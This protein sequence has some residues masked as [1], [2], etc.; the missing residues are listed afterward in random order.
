MTATAAVY[1][2]LADIN[3]NSPR[4]NVSHYRMSVAENM[5]KYSFVGK[6]CI[7][8]YSLDTVIWLCFIAKPLKDWALAVW[9]NHDVSCLGYHQ[10]HLILYY[11]GKV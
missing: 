3:D 1:I 9:G 5:P 11:Y 6:V 7:H 4:F 10:S 2:R 8:I